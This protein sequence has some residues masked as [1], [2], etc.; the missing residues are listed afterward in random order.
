M[1]NKY[2][3]YPQRWGV[4]MNEF[5]FVLGDKNSMFCFC[6]V[7]SAKAGR[8]PVPTVSLEPNTIDIKS[9]GDPPESWLFPFR[10]QSYVCL[11]VE[12]GPIMALMASGLSPQMVWAFCKAVWQSLLCHWSRPSTP[13]SL[14]LE[15]EWIN[16][17]VWERSA[18]LMHFV[19]RSTVI[20]D[21]PASLY[22]HR[23]AATLKTL[24]YS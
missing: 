18:N 1:K 8:N 17:M 16:Q 4:C 15:W 6:S 22:L 2:M 20:R 12:W 19:S 10:E 21:P 24:T 9:K 3:Q 7:T 13:C 14:G 5:D 11:W 23:W